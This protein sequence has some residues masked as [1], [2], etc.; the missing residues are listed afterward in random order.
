MVK[1]VSDDSIEGRKARVNPSQPKGFKCTLRQMLS[2]YKHRRYRLCQQQRE[3]EG[4]IM[5]IG[6]FMSIF[7]VGALYAVYGI[8]ESVVMRERLQDTAD[9]ASF[10]GA[11]TMAHAMNVLGTIH[12]SSMV[13]M[14]VYGGVI[15]AHYLVDTCMSVIDQGGEKIVVIAPNR[16]GPIEEKMEEKTQNC[17]DYSSSENVCNVSRE[18][19]S[20]T[21]MPGFGGF[22]VESL[23]APGDRGSGAR[24]RYGFVD[25]SGPIYATIGNCVC[26]EHIWKKLVERIQNEVD[27]ELHQAAQAEGRVHDLA[28]RAASEAAFLLIDTQQA[29]HHDIKEAYAIGWERGLVAEE[30]DLSENCAATMVA[31]YRVMKALAGGW[32]S[33]ATSAASGGGVGYLQKISRD[34]KIHSRCMRGVHRTGS[35]TGPNVA[36]HFK[37]FDAW[38]S[39][40]YSDPERPQGT[41][42]FQYRVVLLGDMGAVTLARRGAGMPAKILGSVVPF[43]EVAASPTDMLVISQAEY[44][45]PWELSNMSFKDEQNQDPQGRLFVV[46]EE[47]FRTDFRARMRRV[48]TP[49]GVYNKTHEAAM[50]SKWVQELAGNPYCYS[51]GIGYACG[52]LTTYM[53]ALEHTGSVLH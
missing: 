7:M 25:E 33:L 20:T 37:G 24:G 30:T 10:A 12:A 5:L 31:R 38:K 47:M 22:K 53:D 27:A 11:R 39:Y 17:C 1:A 16:R 51:D 14:A 3:N 43:S 35:G 6:T 52:A 34:P 13:H 9:E 29:K 49:T 2:E 15:Q 46:D 40:R 18:A 50:H 41:E 45:T 42:A 44:F 48:R 19:Q 36:I 26:H 28:P 8:G 23:V 21:V 32:H 4:A